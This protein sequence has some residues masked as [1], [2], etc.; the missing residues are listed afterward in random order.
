M[1]QIDAD[2]FSARPDLQRAIIDKTEAS[3]RLHQL[4]KDRQVLS[5]A[6]R[7]DGAHA[8]RRVRIE[9][10]TDELAQDFGLTVSTHLALDHQARTRVR[11]LGDCPISSRGHGEQPMS[12]DGDALPLEAL[13][14]EFLITSL[15]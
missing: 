14:R 8:L 5:L 11:E 4:T 6:R 7:A 3:A 2:V 9:P 10:P 13:L 15:E 12:L 1:L